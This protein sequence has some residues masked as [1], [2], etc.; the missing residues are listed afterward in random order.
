MALPVSRRVDLLEMTT[1]LQL[2][3]MATGEAIAARWMVLSVERIKALFGDDLQASL[4][5]ALIA[6]HSET[7]LHAQTSVQHKDALKSWLEIATPE[8]LEQDAAER[9]SPLLDAAAAAKQKKK[10]KKKPGAD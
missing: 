6:L 8:E 3:A 4:Q 9:L 2:N 7:L 1:A 10:A 5:D